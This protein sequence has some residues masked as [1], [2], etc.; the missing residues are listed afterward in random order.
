ME[1]ESGKALP[2]DEAEPGHAQPRPRTSGGDLGGI[3]PWAASHSPSGRRRTPSCPT[4]A[5]R[6]E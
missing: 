5:V 1:E 6:R 2:C 3:F 4:D